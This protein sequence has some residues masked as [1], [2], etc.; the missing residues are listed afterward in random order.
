[1][2]YLPSLKLSCWDFWSLVSLFTL[3]WVQMVWDKTKHGAGLLH[4][5]INDLLWKKKKKIFLCRSRLKRLQEEF[6]S[7]KM[8]WSALTL[9]THLSQEA[10]QLVLVSDANRLLWAE[11]WASVS[12]GSFPCSGQQQQK[13]ILPLQGWYHSGMYSRSTFRHS[14]VCFNS[15]L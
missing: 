11:I 8:Q 10:R 2:L 1:M 4:K 15:D 7:T 3:L 5:F 6:P 14:C 9:P 12:S 13:G